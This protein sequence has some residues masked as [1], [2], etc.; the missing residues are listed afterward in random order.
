MK[1]LPIALALAAIT[2][3]AAHAVDKVYSFEDFEAGTPNY[4]F[5]GAGNE[6]IL[7]GLTPAQALTGTDYLPDSTS[8]MGVVANGEPL[9]ISPAGEPTGQHGFFST[10][11]NRS[12]I[13]RDPM[14]LVTD[15][16][17]SI[18]VDFSFLQYGNGFPA[19]G[20][21]ILI[22]SALGDFSDAV[23]VASF[24]IGQAGSW[25]ETPDYPVVQ[26]TWNSVSVTITNGM[27][28]NTYTDNAIGYTTPSTVEFT[29]TAKF[30][31][32]RVPV[33]VT[34]PDSTTNH[35]ILIDDITIT[36]IP[37]PAPSAPFAAT[38]APAVDPNTGY[39]LQ[40]TSQAGKTYSV[41]SSTD[42]ATPVDSWT[43]VQTGIAPTPPQNSYNVPADGVRR[44]Y[45][46]KEMAP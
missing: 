10:S 41:L 6:T 21:A 42:L 25:I 1:K 2:A 35:I 31:I 23:Q 17:G 4:T 30:K 22:Y 45:V 46:I 3:G 26:D 36:G 5:D 24:G 33:S 16:A 15:G 9:A 13:L 12:L 38:I 27:S 8:R 44:F 14:T 20:S 29:D 18:Q 34:A 43:V 7:G 40:W 19:T 28:A 39:D 11:Q 32:N 37:A